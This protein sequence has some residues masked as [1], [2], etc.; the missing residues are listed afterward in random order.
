MMATC[1]ARV[2]VTAMPLRD[3]KGL[4]IKTEQWLKSVGVHSEEQLKELGAIKVYVRL[5]NS[6]DFKPNSCFLYAL[7]G[8]L[9]D[10]SWLDVAR[11]EKT[12][13]MF[14][15]ESELALEKLLKT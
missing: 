2:R 8:A 13:L 10:R 5:L 3:L 12:R 14:E 1:N 15:L 6:P 11:N 7:E 9:S 4:G